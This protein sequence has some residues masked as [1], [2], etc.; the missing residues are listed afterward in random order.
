MESTPPR[1]SE[2]KPDEESGPISSLGALAS[3]QARTSARK[4]A[5]CGLSSKFMALT[6]SGRV[7]LAHALDQGV[8]PLR[9]GA[10]VQRQQ[11]GAAVVE[12]GVEGPG[13]GHCGVDPEGGA[14][15]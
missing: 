9:Q 5:S 2:P 4:A 15:A 1:F 3:I 11:V 12:G 14:C 6:P 10:Q 8:L 13:E 7:A